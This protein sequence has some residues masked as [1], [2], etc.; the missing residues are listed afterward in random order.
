MGAMT[1]GIAAVVLALFVG[2][3][4]CDPTGTC[5]QTATPLC[6]EGWAKSDCENLAAQAADAGATN[7]FVF[8]GSQTC[9]ELGF[10]QACS[11]AETCSAGAGSA[12][13]S[14]MPNNPYC[15]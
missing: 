7:T 15:P 12:C 5:V 14:C 1:R 13:C 11:R 9:T 2:L 4:G 10:T 3:A 6:H 8:Y